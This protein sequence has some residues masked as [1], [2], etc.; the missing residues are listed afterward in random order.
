MVQ[1]GRF[2]LPFFDD[3]SK[4]LQNPA[5]AHVDL[6]WELIKL[7]RVAILARTLFFFLGGGLEA[8]LIVV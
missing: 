5:L 6:P 8:L 1:M 7:L 4:I 2:I 3:D